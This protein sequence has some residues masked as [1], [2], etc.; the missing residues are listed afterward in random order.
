MTVAEYVPKI[1]TAIIYAEM[2]TNRQEY[3]WGVVL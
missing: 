3:D 1:T 2:H